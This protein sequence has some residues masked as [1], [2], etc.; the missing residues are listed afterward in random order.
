MKRKEIQSAILDF[1]T[2]ERMTAQEI[3]T[4]MKL[5]FTVVAVRY[6]LDTLVMTGKI[7][8]ITDSEKMPDGRN[9]RVIKY[10]K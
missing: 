8:S 3:L 4:A 5:P 7:K 9:H 2:S 6:H 1:L 10:W